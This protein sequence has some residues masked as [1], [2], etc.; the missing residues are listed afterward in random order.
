[1]PL[2]DDRTDDRTRPRTRPGPGRSR[3][4][5]PAAAALAAVVA[6]AGAFAAGCDP[7]PL[8]DRLCHGSPALRCLHTLLRSH[9]IRA[10]AAVPAAAH[11]VSTVDPGRR[12]RAS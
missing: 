12:E 3:R 8:R 10:A 5:R 7:A 6:A 4:R 1:M 2:R 11:A 9:G